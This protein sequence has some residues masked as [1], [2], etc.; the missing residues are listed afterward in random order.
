MLPEVWVW[1]SGLPLDVRVDYLS[2]W[3]LGTLF[4][5]TLDVYMSYTRKNKVLRTKIGCLDYKLI[6]ADSDMFIRRG[7]S[8]LGFEVEIAA[9]SEEVNMVNANNG[10]DGND[11]ANQGEKKFGGAHEM[12]MDNKGNDMDATS[13]NDEQDDS[14]MHNC[15]DGMQEQLCNLDAIQIGTLHVKLAPTGTLSVAKNLNKNEQVCSSISH[16][17]VAPQNDESRTPFLADGD[18]SRDLLL[19]GIGI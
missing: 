14:S 18:P 17:E 11:G 6:P 19:P 12:D 8:K 3:G 10:L 15:V 13:K 9:Q 16:V 2:L 7:F 5:K 4:G 1:V